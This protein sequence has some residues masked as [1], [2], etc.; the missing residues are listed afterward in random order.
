M[1]LDPEEGVAAGDEPEDV[2][3]S[4]MTVVLVEAT[5]VREGAVGPTMK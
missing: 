2:N 5:V 1:K 3:G 4:K